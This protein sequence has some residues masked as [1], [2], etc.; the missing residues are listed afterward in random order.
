M[1]RRTCSC[2]DRPLAKRTAPALGVFAMSAPI[3]IFEVNPEHDTAALAKAFATN[4]RIQIRDMLTTPSARALREALAK[5]TPWGMAM[6]AAEGKPQD[7]RLEEMRDPAGGQRAQALNEEVHRAA[8]RG[9]YAFRYARYPMVKAYQER[10][11]PGGLHDV[12]IEH[13]NTEPFL[14]LVRRVTGFDDLLKADGQATLF[15][16]QHFLGLHQD[17]QLEEG[18]KVAYVLNLSPDVWKPD[19]GGYLMFYDDE[20]DAVEGFMP[21]FN[22]LNLFAVPQHHAVTYVPPFAPQGRIAISGWFRER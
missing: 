9:D 7:F 16:R 6:Q 17:Q 19:W 5:E 4:R 14:E 22:T 2:R 8:E 21:R 15:S 11:N 10:W 13:I 1:G 20:G 12:L 18:W 3:N